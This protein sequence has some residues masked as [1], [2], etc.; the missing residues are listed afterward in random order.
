M[1]KKRC[2]KEKN[3][4]KVDDILTQF[5]VNKIKNPE[6]ATDRIYETNF[7]SAHDFFCFEMV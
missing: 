1:I 3:N 7:I 6:Y 2:L 4:K 5:Y